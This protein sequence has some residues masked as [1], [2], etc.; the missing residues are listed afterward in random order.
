M[1]VNAKLLS[2]SSKACVPA[3]KGRSFIQ[4]IFCKIQALQGFAGRLM[5][6][7]WPKSAAHAIPSSCWLAGWWQ[8]TFLLIA[9]ACR[10]ANCPF[11]AACRQPQTARLR[12][13][14]QPKMHGCMVPAQPPR[15]C[16]G[17]LTQ[18]H[19]PPGTSGGGWHWPAARH[20]P[21]HRPL[22]CST[23]SEWRGS[24]GPKSSVPQSGGR[25]LSLMPHD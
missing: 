5:L 15:R 21:K 7:G 16:H 9:V 1:R 23:R 14:Q 10:I 4:G 13:R 2:L 11:D 20:A 17:P 12:I 24:A 3:R 8:C 22:G 18:C 25:W 19:K 6:V